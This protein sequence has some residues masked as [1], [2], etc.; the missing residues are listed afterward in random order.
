MKEIWKK[1]E[2][3]PQYE[4]SNFGRVKNTI[5]KYGHNMRYAKNETTTLKGNIG[6]HGYRVV[7]LKGK[8]HLVHR[9]VAQAFIHNKENKPQVNHKD[10]N[11]LNN[12]VS[13]LEWVTSKENNIHARLLNV[14]KDADTRTAFAKPRA[15][16]VNQY[17]LNHN[18]I[19]SYLGSKEA[20]L[21]LRDLGIKVNARNIRSVCEGNRRKAGG[22]YW[23][24]ASETGD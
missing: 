15:K 23:E 6:N 14:Y 8:S 24:Y 3:C 16:I 1:I 4:I 21:I 11:K 9:L 19:R 5:K 17:D 22:F 20:E 7:D 12:N 10:L 2:S 13:N 18:Y